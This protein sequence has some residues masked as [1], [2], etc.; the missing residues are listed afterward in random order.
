MTNEIQIFTFNDHPVR[1]VEKDGEP[2]WVAKDVCDILE[3]E[4]SRSSLALLD[5]D[6]KSIVHIMDGTSPLGGNPNMTVISEPGL[7]RLIL[8]SRKPQAKTFQRWVTHDVLPAIRKTGSYALEGFNIPQTLPEALRL[9]ASLEEE[10]AVLAARIEQDKPYTALGRSLGYVM[11]ETS[12]GQMAVILSQSLG[13]KISRT[14]LFG[15]LERDEILCIT[16][17]EYHRP[18]QKY[19]D[20]GYMNYRVHEIST[21]KGM[22]KTFTPYFTPAG[23]VFIEKHYLEKG[24]EI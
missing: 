22:K 21:V 15:L 8:R 1:I 24:T 7:Y 13:K 18:R 12:V 14:K 4:N 9:A 19:I 20:K 23:R 17:S 3:L 5:E 2:W 10:R 11:G 6:E 16:P